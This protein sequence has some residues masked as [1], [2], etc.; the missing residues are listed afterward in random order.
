[1]INKMSIYIIIILF[2]YVRT[3]IY[4]VRVIGSIPVLNSLNT[5]IQV[6]SQ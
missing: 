4:V 6:E 1:M 5:V 3:P 2:Y